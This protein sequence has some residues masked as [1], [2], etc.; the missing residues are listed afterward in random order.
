MTPQGGARLRT[1]S[2]E[3]L[4]ALWQRGNALA[5]QMLCE[6]LEGTVYRALHQIVGTWS[7]FSW[8]EVEDLRNEV[9]ARLALAIGRFR[10]ECSVRTYAVSITRRCALELRRRRMALARGAGQQAEGLTDMPAGRE[11]SDDR[12]TPQ[13]EA[14][15]QAT[16]D[17]VRETVDGLGPECRRLIRMKWFEE[18]TLP[19]I[20]SAVGRDP[21]VVSRR[22]RHCLDMLVAPLQARGVLAPPE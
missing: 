1:Y 8:D 2:E 11:P 19:Q 7:C 10:G 14:L 21:S 13:D 18:L 4:A 17:A 5:G 3:A 22:L 12:P 15:R 9:F 16:I 6:R 20:A